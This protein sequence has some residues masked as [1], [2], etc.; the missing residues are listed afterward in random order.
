M[1]ALPRRGLNRRGQGSTQGGRW[2]GPRQKRGEI[3]G[4]GCGG[5]VTKAKGVG[6]EVYRVGKVIQVW[7]RKGR[8]GPFVLTPPPQ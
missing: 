1:A 7:V 8:G 6:K 3:A 2:W 4:K 5:V